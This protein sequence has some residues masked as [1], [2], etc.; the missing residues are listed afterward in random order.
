MKRRLWHLAQLKTETVFKVTLPAAKS[1]IV[2]AVVLGIGRAIGE[3]MAVM[4]VAGNVANMP[5]LFKSVLSYNGG[6]GKRNVLFIRLAKAGIVF[7]R[8][9]LVYLHNGNKHYS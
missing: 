1:G 9:N 5:S 6:G 7:Y 2:T 3:A 8:T 4:M